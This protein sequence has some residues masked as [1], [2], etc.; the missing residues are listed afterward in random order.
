[1]IRGANS[2]DV[3]PRNESK[4]SEEVTK[5]YGD[6]RSIDEISKTWK[7][8]RSWAAVHLRALRALPE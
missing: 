5:R 8:F 1:M 4:L 7:P 3:L 2:P 6:D